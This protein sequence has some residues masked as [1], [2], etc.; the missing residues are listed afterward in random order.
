MRFGIRNCGVIWSGMMLV[1]ACSLANGDEEELADAAVNLG[2][3]A[4]AVD[5]YVRFGDDAGQL[6]SDELIRN[7]TSENPALLSSLSAY[8]IRA[9]RDGK[10][11]SVLLCDLES[12]VAY[13]EDAG[14]TSG[15]LD[16]NYF[17]GPEKSQKAC[18]F[19]LNLAETCPPR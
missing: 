18:E 8:V 6:S 16:A 17:D 12:R 2:Y 7:A 15:K 9:R 4:T 19:R 14:C 10:Y 13:A 1:A 5:G 11:S 3:I